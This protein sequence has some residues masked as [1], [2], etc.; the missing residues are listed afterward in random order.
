VTSNT[1]VSKA[2]KLAAEINAVL[3][4]EALQMASDP[5][6]VVHYLSTGVLAMDVL[7]QGGLPR[8][9]F[10]EVYGDYSTLKSYIGYRAIATTQSAGGTCALVDTE[11]SFDPEWASFLGVDVEELIIRRPQ[12]GEE[13][14]D[15]S[16]L[17]IRNGVDL[18]V[19]DSVAATLPQ[20]EQKKRMSKENIQPARLA[21]LMSAA[22]RR[23]TAANENTA[24]LFINQTR[25]NVGVMFG[26]PTSIPGGKALGF[27]TSFRISLR[28]AGK[29]ITTHKRQVPGDLPGKLKTADVKQV[30]GYRIKA[31][32]EKSKLSAP[33]ADT[34]LYFDLTTGALDDVGFTISKCLE[35]GLIEKKGNTYW[36]LQK[37]A[38]VGSDALRG[39]MQKNP[40]VMDQLRA[41]LLGLD[42]GSQGPVKRTVVRLKRK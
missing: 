2:R 36:V 9:R 40:E 20:D 7:L 16:E 26:D 3:G 35:T 25:L 14:V 21:Q 24:V 5:K 38:A 15:V 31:T 33:Y 8:G 12:T 39:W 17:L 37:K 41:T 42:S 32:I 10:V 23:L 4:E 19:W 6:Y 34:M 22:S 13:A 30:E 18:I 1:K 11:H 28:K 29:V 27:Y